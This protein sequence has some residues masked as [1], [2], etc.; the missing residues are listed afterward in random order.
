MKIIRA[1]IYILLF[2]IAS[3]VTLQAQE[4][5]QITNTI[6]TPVSCFGYTDGSLQV[7]V[8]GGSGLYNYLL[9]KLPD[10]L[11]ESSGLIP[12]QSY[13]F[14]NLE[15]HLYLILVVGE[16]T[17]E[18]DPG[19]AFDYVDGPGPINITSAVAEDISCNGFDD[20]SISVTATGE[21][22]NHI[23]TL[24][25]P[26]NAVNNDGQFPGLIEGSYTVTVTDGN[27][28]SSD[29][30]ESLTITN[31]PPLSVTLDEVTDVECNG[32][33][34]GAISI[35]V[36]GGT[37][38]G[39]GTGYTYVWTGPG[40]NGSTED[41][42]NVGAGNYGVTVRDVNACEAGLGPVTIDE[43][44]P[45]VMVVDNVTDITCNGDNNGAIEVS[46]S[47]GTPGLTFLWSGPD[48]YSATTEDIS[49]LTS[50]VYQL[51]VTDSRSCEQV[52]EA[53][54]VSQP[55]SL[56]ATAISEDISCFGNG[57]GS[58]DLTVSG[59]VGGYVYNWTGPGGFNESTED[60]SDLQ[61]GEYSVNIT[62]GNGCLLEMAPIASIGEPDSL[63]VT[64]AS[65]D[66]TCH[67]ASNGSIFV[68]VTGGT[69]PFQ[70]DWS[71]P[72]GFSSTAQDI[73]GLGP[74]VYDLQLSDANLC[75]ASYPGLDT[76]TEPA[77]IRVTYRSQINPTCNGETDGAIF[78]NVS[79]GTPPLS[80]NWTDESGTTVDTV[81]NPVNLT[82]GAYGLT[83][84]DANGCF[85]IADIVANLVDPAPLV[86]T[87]TSEDVSCFGGADGSVTVSTAGGRSPYEYSIE[88]DIDSTYQEEG[89]F[90]SMPAG[91]L[92]VWT[93]D[94]NL[95]VTTS[96]ITLLS[97]DTIIIT[98]E[99]VTGTIL[100]HGD[101]S[102]QISIG[103]VTGGTGPFTYSIDNGDEFVVSPDFTDLPAGN[104]QTVVKDARGCTAMGALHLIS[105]PDP[106]EFSDLQ[107]FD[108]TT[109]A[110]AEEGRI[111]AVAGG[112]T[113]P[114]SY[115]LNGTENNATGDFTGLAAGTYEVLITDGNACNADTSVTVQAPDP[116]VFEQIDI[117]NV[118]GCYGDANG[119]IS[120]TT[121]S[122]GTTPLRYSL[123]GINFFASKNFNAL[124]AGT[125]TITVLDDN[126]CSNDST[127]TITQ[128]DSLAIQSATVTQ[129]TCADAANG[130]IEITAT[131]GT[132]PLEYTL[133]PPGTTNDNGIFTGLAPDIYTAL[134][135]DAEGCAPVASEP[136]FVTGPPAL[137]PDSV[138]ESP[139]SCNGADDG[140]IT[141]YASGGTPPYQYSV[142]NQTSWSAD[143]LFTGLAAGDYDL[144]LRDTS[145]CVSPAGQVTL[146]EP[147]ALLLSVT[148]TDIT[149]CWYDSTGSIEASGN[150]GTG[151]LFYSIDGVNYQD[152]GIFVNL[153]A[154]PYTVFLRDETGCETSEAI[155]LLAPEAITATITKTDALFES[156]GSITIESSSGGVPPYAYSIHGPAG[157]FT[158]DTFYSDL[159]AGTYPVIVRDQNGC[160]Y[161][162]MVEILDV[163]PLEVTVNA[164]NVSC[165]GA[166]D[167][168][169]EMVP[170]NAVGTV[171]YSIDSGINF[172]P[173]PLFE[174]LPGNAIYYLMA[175]DEEGKVFMDSVTLTEPTDLLLTGNVTP[176]ECNAFS[177]TGSISIAVSGGTSGYA[178]LWSDGSTE[179]DRSA[180]VAGTYILT[181]SDANGCT[182]LDT[183][184]VGSL[185]TVVAN[186]G[187][188]TTVCYGGSLQLNGQG[189]HTPS[190]DPSPFLSDPSIA[191]PVAS[192]I[193]EETSFVL[194]ITEDTSPF[195]CY[196]TDTIHV[197]LYPHV[198]IS[199]TPDTLIMSGNPVQLNVS[200]GPFTSYR[201]DPVTWL[202]NSMLQDP[203]ATPEEP[204]W[205]RVYATNEY[206]CEEMDSLFIDVIEELKAYNVFSPNGDGV[207]DYFEIDFAENFP[208]MRVE[209]YSRWGDLLYSTVGYDSG[210]RWDG[211]TR[212][213]EAPVGTYYYIIIPYSGARPI[214][215]NV[216]IIR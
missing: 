6:P 107:L 83:V 185:I 123:D 207:N 48:G 212:G 115:T 70:F 188:D 198:E 57:D 47:G 129:V 190:W 79:G 98:E 5:I 127:V 214:T 25:G 36:S 95:C 75:T 134:V 150:G 176:A 136:I 49:L 74:G 99:T 103:E 92:T 86:S 174:D 167:G 27:C 163:L 144:F 16:D 184:R 170:Q 162:E 122:G 102:V 73:S 60:I 200:G 29:V 35:D 182:R 112:G 41:L 132:E 34:T 153:T 45:I 50:G 97:P 77:P 76:I 30:T 68:T 186:A 192:G 8:S 215:G 78:V 193:T 175:R 81:Q 46:V 145:L 133:M 10:I 196:D 159:A 22:G 120:V 177:E 96:E 40:F 33:E 206:G 149:T 124:P 213:T 161:E 169:I 130:V 165:Y 91:T 164:T 82:A 89:A 203:V 26:E 194:T 166:G 195:G 55:D 56:S 64:F 168:S 80:F 180:I 67:G 191:D 14:T 201:W 72:S 116:L 58:V 105:Q 13:T 17:T 54:T 38:G 66:I 106:L 179:E 154:G 3:V 21:S 204:V 208:D 155:T 139:I 90:N 121:I 111:L 39:G 140:S 87:L 156:L 118:T 110:D 131:G 42:I 183:F 63:F 71:G 137:V 4:G 109:C 197:A 178:F 61:A 141:I 28:P 146:S 126:G 94:N 205:Y 152:S 84:T 43:P 7:E 202:D 12:E 147:P 59:G 1:G 24:T 181:T 62:D 104:Y 93:R 108:V 157:P 135:T 20:G 11:V 210:S 32:A 172:V 9:L 211:T 88:G 158:A 189:S 69:E 2:L 138:T 128:P 151:I 53:V 85:Y 148:G 125:Y 19:T 114:Y 143:S 52:M 51:T 23:Y 160:D 171:E 37:P 44:A 65:N 101:S 117:T 18:E 199:A 100:C 15:K 187:E 216:T 173:D 31:P 119:S 209:I 142:D 113:V